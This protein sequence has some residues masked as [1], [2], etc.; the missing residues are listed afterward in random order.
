MS[1]LVCLL[2]NLNNTISYILLN[3]LTLNYKHKINLK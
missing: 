1:T 3:T 2:K